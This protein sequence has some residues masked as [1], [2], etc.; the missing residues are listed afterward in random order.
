MTEGG[1][2][3]PGRW[4][5]IV[6]LWLFATGVVLYW[7]SFFFGG[8]VHAAQDDCYFI[9]Q[10]NFPVPDIVTAIA[11]LLCAEGLRRGRGWGLIWGGVAAGGIL[12]LGL[13]D[14]SYNVWNGMYAN[15]SLAML[16]ENLINIYCLVFG[17]YLVWYV[18]KHQGA[19]A[20]A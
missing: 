7:L 8:E 9:F 17:P 20:Y 11:G 12:F 18:M 1:N 6:S 19:M 15:M 10:R 14:V 13:I 2:S 3:F 4:P 5:V 16:N